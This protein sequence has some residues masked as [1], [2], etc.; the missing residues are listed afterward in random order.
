MP[1]GF[2]HCPAGL[3]RELAAWLLPTALAT[4]Q[5]PTLVATLLEELRARRI[6]CP[7]LAAIERRAG[8]VRARKQRQLWRQ[9]AD[10]LTDQQRQSLDQ[11]LEVRVGGGQSTLAWLRQTA[12]AATTALL[13]DSTAARVGALFQ[14]LVQDTTAQD[15]GLPSSAIRLRM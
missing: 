15:F 7:P 13:H 8:S 5:G 12:Y 9:L 3:Y 1:W 2:A 10:E 14:L 11:L 6:V 4:D